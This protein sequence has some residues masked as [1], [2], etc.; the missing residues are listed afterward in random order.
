MSNVDLCARAQ[1]ELFGAGRLELA[2]E[3]LTEDCIDHGGEVGPMP[4]GASQGREAIAGVV[5]WLRGAFPDLSYEVDDAF[6]DGDRVAIRCT[7][8]GTH[9][10]EFLG[11]P[12]TG[13]RFAVQQI[14]VFRM[15]DGRIA[16][17]WACRDDAGMMKQLGFF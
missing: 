3:L 16:E 2:E 8:S 14:H 5:Q 1:Q 4:S 10:G 12:A 6:G 13:N 15:E 9:E 7:V 17:H 11:R